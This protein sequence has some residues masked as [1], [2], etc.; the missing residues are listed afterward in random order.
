MQNSDS[1]VIMAQILTASSSSSDLSLHVDGGTTI[2]PSSDPLKKSPSVEYVPSIA[3]TTTT[4]TTRVQ[5]GG[6]NNKN[7]NINIQSLS[8]DPTL[9][10][11]YNVSGGSSEGGDE[12]VCA[13][14]KS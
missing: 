8:R 2:L 4:T 5:S 11:K 12:T 3:T 13:D 6:N 7:S 14:P 9:D 10:I 1:E